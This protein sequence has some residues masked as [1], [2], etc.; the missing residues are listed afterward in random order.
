M[1]FDRKQ[2]EKILSLDNESFVSIAKS[3]AEAA[4]ASRLQTEAMLANPDVIKQR[5]AQM[6]EADANRILQAAGREKSEEILSVL[7]ERGVDV[8]R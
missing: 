8:G 1:N 2:L 7:R 6:S 5:I 3:I 4:G